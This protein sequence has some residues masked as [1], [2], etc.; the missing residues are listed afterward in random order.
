MNIKD[1]LVSVYKAIDTISIKG[2]DVYTIVGIKNVLG[3]IISSLEKQTKNDNKE[4]D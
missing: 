1:S 3:E 2:A 4:G